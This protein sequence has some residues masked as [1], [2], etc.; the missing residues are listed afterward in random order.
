MKY[1]I[2]SISLWSFVKQCFF[3]SLV[4]GFIVGI[5]YGLFIGLM[6]NMSSRFDFLRDMDED[7]VAAS[8]GMIMVVTPIA[9]AL[10]ACAFNTL[11]GSV[12]VICYNMFARFLGGLEMELAVV[13]AETPTALA[14]RPTVAP[15]GDSMIPPPPPPYGAP[16][17]PPPASHPEPRQPEPPASKYE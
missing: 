14:P 4:I 15:M 7:M 5:F 2:R 12:C 11:I 8:S 9:M 1:E 6:V 13:P 17:A 16:V 3:L 10:M